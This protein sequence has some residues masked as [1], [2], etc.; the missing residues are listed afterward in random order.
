[1]PVFDY[2]DAAKILSRQLSQAGYHDDAAAIDMALDEGSTG[3][4]ICMI[5]RYHLG[6]ILEND[7]LDEP[8]KPQIAELYTELDSIL[9]NIS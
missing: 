1:M 3:N 5:L 7:D 4:E 9:N 6:N 2:I 8:L